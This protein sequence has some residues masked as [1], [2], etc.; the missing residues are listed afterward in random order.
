[1]CTCHEIIIDNPDFISTEIVV[2]S[3]TRFNVTDE[4]LVCP[5]TM[6]NRNT[7]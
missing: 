6:N 1:M 2:G 5:L 7:C 4:S 3:Q